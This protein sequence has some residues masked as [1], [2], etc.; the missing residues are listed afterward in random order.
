MYF[1]LFIYSHESMPT[2]TFGGVRRYGRLDKP[3]QP[4][5]PRQPASRMAVL[6]RDHGHTMQPLLRWLYRMRYG[7]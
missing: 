3:R 1:R 6:L 4:R 5:Q 7:L 2:R